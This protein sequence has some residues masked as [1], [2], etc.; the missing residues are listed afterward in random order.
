MLVATGATSTILHA[1]HEALWHDRN[2]LC[3]LADLTDPWD[4]EPTCRACL[5]TLQQIA[6][7]ERQA[8]LDD[9]MRE[10]MGT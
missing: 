10:R 8:E 3:G 5:R 9:F 6:L 1:Y 2:S 7:N 4:G